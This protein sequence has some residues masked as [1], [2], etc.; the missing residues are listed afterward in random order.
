MFWGNKR[1]IKFAHKADKLRLDILYKYGGI[2]MD[3]DTISY[4]SYKDYLNY[5]FVIG[6]QEENYENKNI[7]LY[8]N[9]ILFSK[10]NNIFIEKWINEYENHFIPQGWCEASVHLP[11]IIFN[12]LSI[13]EK[14]NIKIL[15]KNVFIILY[16]MKLKRYLKII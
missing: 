8:C 13:N 5:D 7:T 3:I 14:S 2:Y 4:K 12:N 11:S 16:I 15:E 1:I 10:K 6:I 9:A